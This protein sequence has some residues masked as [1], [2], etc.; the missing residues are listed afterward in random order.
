IGFAA[1]T[2]G[3]DEYNPEVPTTYYEADETYTGSGIAAKWDFT[4]LSSDAAVTDTVWGLTNS[5]AEFPETGFGANGGLKQADGTESAGAVLVP[6][7]AWKKNQGNGSTI[8]DKDGVA[9]SKNSNSSSLDKFDEA[10]GF[11]LTLSQPANIVV[12]GR[13]AGAAAPTRFIIIADASGKKLAY[14]ANLRNSKAEEFVVKGAPA[15][16][17]KI[18]VNGS[19]VYYIDLSKSS[20]GLK[21]PA[22]IT[23]LKLYDKAGT[24]EASA[25]IDSFEVYESVTFTAMN[26][27]SEG[28]TE[29]MT[30][31]AV[32]TSS[33]ENI[34]E[35][36]GGV[37]TGT[38][39]GTAII[40][41]RIGRFYDERT[42]TVTKS[43]K[44][45]ITFIS[46]DKLPTTDVL[47]LT[48]GNDTKTVDDF[49]KAEELKP[50]LQNTVSGGFATAT[51]ATLAF[52]SAF[53]FLTGDNAKAGFLKKGDI[54]D[55]DG[56]FGLYWRSANYAS[57]PGSSSPLEEATF[58]FKVMPTGTSA[59]LSRLTALT[60][61]N[62]GSSNHKLKVTVGDKEF[63]SGF[64]KP[65]AITDIDLDELEITT[66]TEIKVSV[67]V[68]TNGTRTGLQDLKLYVTE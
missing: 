31:D 53:A 55:G 35:V 58:T 63:T 41:A 46:G 57:A 23:E 16:E 67:E 32:W 25:E 65:A 13:G 5:E 39:E 18:Y 26:V 19:C 4:N 6:I 1:C 12:K 56:S 20:A 28:E 68:M 11:T 54:G 49:L 8:A 22:Q 29:D 30:A 15:G 62:K 64:N 51:G 50:L 9:Q 2:D 33:D 10:A 37:V 59:K 60:S 48:K 7:G 45:I 27:V 38:G 21:E 34:A 66:E 61:S 14:K 3:N 24:A 36:K 17:Y 47:L 40:R 44:T 42:V 43:T 52:N